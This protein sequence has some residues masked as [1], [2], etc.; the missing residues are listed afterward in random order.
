M[1]IDL[2]KSEPV[3]IGE[4]IV[5]DTIRLSY[6]KEKQAYYATRLGVVEKININSDDEVESVLLADHVAGNEEYLDEPELRLFLKSRIGTI[7]RYPEVTPLPSKPVAEE[8]K[9]V[10]FT[11]PQGK[12]AYLRIENVD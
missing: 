6:K 10:T 2:S 4:L 5:G 1:A 7:D 12:K 9:V 11:I 3:S 8:E